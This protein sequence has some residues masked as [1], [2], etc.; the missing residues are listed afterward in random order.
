MRYLKLKIAEAEEMKARAGDVSTFRRIEDGILEMSGGLKELKQWSRELELDPRY[1]KLIRH[2]DG[3]LRP[4]LPVF[5][6][7]KDVEAALENR[8]GTLTGLSEQDVLRAREWLAKE[9]AEVSIRN[10]DGRSPY[11]PDEERKP[12]RGSI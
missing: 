12:P 9:D 3:M 7:K 10:M 1:G 11:I 6:R 4:K 8:A 5:E 2:S